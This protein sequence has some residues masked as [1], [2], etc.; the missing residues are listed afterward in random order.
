MFDGFRMFFNGFIVVVFTGCF[1]GFII[2]FNCCFNGSLVAFIDFDCFYYWMP[3][4]SL[5]V[6]GF[7]R[8]HYCFY[9]FVFNGVLMVL[10]I[11]NWFIICFNGCCN[12]FIFVLTFFV[13]GFLMGFNWLFKVFLS[14]FSVVVNG[15]LMIFKGFV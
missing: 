11:F 12:D 3:R 8:F 4:F 7:W 15:C 10:I 5:R 9:G 13:N 6:K 2:A 14:V 1:N